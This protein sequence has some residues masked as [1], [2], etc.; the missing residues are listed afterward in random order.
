VELYVLDRSLQRVEVIDKF[1]SLIWTERFQDQGDFE[2]TLYSTKSLRTLLTY[3]TMVSINK[4][5]RIMTIEEVENKTETDGKKTLIVRGQSL[6]KI[7][8]DRIATYDLSTKVSDSLYKGTVT[9]NST[10]DY[11]D[12]TSNHD[13]KDGDEIYFKS[14][15]GLIGKFVGNISNFSIASNYF[16]IYKHGL[17][18]GDKVYVKTAGTLPTGVTS[19]QMYY[20]IVVDADRL[21]LA[22]NATDAKNSAAIDFTGTSSGAHGI[23]SALNDL[24]TYYVIKVNDTRLKLAETYE[25]AFSANIEY[26]PLDLFGTVTGTNKLY[27]LHK[28]TWRI[29]GTPRQILEGIFNKFCVTPYDSLDT[30]FIYTPGSLYPNNGDLP[31]ISTEYV[32]DLK[33]SSVYTVIKQLCE[34]WNFGFRITRSNSYNKVYFNIYSGS[35]RTMSGTSAVIFDIDLENLVNETEYTSNKYYKNIA[36]VY[37]KYGS[38]IVYSDSA[39]EFSTGFDKK[40]IYVDATDIDIYPGTELENLLQQRGREVLNARKTIVAFDG[41]VSKTND[42]VYEIDYFLGDLVEVKDI[43][44][45]STIK[46]VTEQ[47]FTDDREGERSFPTLSS[48]I[49]VPTG[50]WAVENVD[51]TWNDVTITIKWSDL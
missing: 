51:K 18:D 17:N 35:N 6:E 13:L 28:E 32:L 20:A 26:A 49:S 44:G 48:Q 34:I 19:G 30:L 24:Q 15:V 3:G 1:E 43:D 16:V 21:S 10:F 7:L 42:Y 9:F 31:E 2:L 46:R 22:A 45:N 5:N 11:L 37:S 40:I 36:H 23:Y 41:E 38:S 14:S 12:T 33:V 25:A 50:S 27:Y 47:I 8:D 4:S 29:K 39:E